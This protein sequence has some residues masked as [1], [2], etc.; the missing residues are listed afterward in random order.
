MQVN[1]TTMY[2]L[3]YLSSMPGGNGLCWEVSGSSE[4]A[5]SRNT[6]LQRAHA[7]TNT[8]HAYIIASVTLIMLRKKSTSLQVGRTSTSFIEPAHCGV[9]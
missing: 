6:A 9:E 7:Q 2:V 5:E 3:S 1:T 8:T 4:A